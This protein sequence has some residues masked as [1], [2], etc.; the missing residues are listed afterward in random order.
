MLVPFKNSFRHSWRTKALWFS[1]MRGSGPGIFFFET[2]RSF[3]CWDI[4][5]SEAFRSLNVTVVLKL[6]V[7]VSISQYFQTFWPKWL[8]FFRSFQRHI[9]L[10]QKFQHQ[11]HTNSYQNNLVHQKN[12][13]TMQQFRPGVSQLRPAGQM[14]PAK[15]FCRWWKIIC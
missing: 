4:L 14:L 1:Q 5:V 13:T 3:F 15:Q 10:W 7:A 2:F 9:G 8:N 6:A 11:S 12:S